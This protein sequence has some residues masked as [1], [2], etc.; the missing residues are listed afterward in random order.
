MSDSTAV[1]L[2]DFAAVLVF[3]A[4]CWGT[5]VLTWRLA[6]TTMDFF[7]DEIDIY[8]NKKYQPIHIQPE[9]ISR[10]LRYIDREITFARPR[11]E[12]YRANRSN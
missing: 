7:L 11:T 3:I 12:Q 6:V 10:R 9:Y 1:Y 4:F 2:L 8:Y 5:L